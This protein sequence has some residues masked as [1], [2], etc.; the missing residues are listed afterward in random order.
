LTANVCAISATSFS[1]YSDIA[2]FSVSHIDDRES[3]SY[4]IM[5]SG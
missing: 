1:G 2:C 4:W 3:G 5:S